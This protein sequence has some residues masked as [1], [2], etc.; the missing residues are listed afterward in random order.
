MAT[1][2]EVKAQIRFALEQL[3]AM[4]AH[5]EFEH[6]CLDLTRLR[7]CSNVLPATGPVAAGGDQ[8]RDF[9]TFR[10]Y[11]KATPIAN[12]TFIGLVSTKRLVF[13]CS[14]GRK[15]TLLQDQG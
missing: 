13:P 12:T 3:S 7:I 8:G 1:L 10:T 6:R 2:A 5:H 9:E 15:R 14:L 11:L 4:N